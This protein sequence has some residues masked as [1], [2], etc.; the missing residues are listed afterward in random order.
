MRARKRS[1]R[2]QI[3]LAIVLALL[4]TVLLVSVLSNALINRRFEAY[5]IRQQEVRTE[6]IIA[7][8][9]DQYDAL[10]GVWDLEFIHAVGMSALYDGYIVKLYDKAGGMVWDAENHDMTLCGQIMEEIAKRMKAWNPGASGEF[11]SHEYGLS[12]N[13][14]AAGRVVILYF[15][16]YF[17][18]E[19][20]FA[21]L[22]ALNAVL[23]AMGIVS[24][25]FSLVAG[26]FL[27]RRI[28]RPISGAAGI[29]RQIAAGNYSIRFESETGT[30]ELDELIR[31]VNHLAGALEEQEGIRKQLTA[32]VAH[33]LR[34]PL[35]AAGSHLEAMLEGV[36]EPTPQRLESC[37]EEIKRLS[38]LVSDMERLA[39]VERSG[40]KLHMAEVDLMD[41]VRAVCGNFEKDIR[42]KGLRLRI[43]GESCLL[44]ADRDRLGQI[45][46][47]L[48]SNAGKFT[49]A[50]GT[51]RVGAARSGANAVLTVADDGVGIS[52]NELPFIFER[53][54]RADKSRNRKTGGAGIG[55]AI[56]KSIAEAHGG[57]VAAESRPDRGSC[58]TVTLP[59]AL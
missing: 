29:A 32:D 39:Q 3:S 23:I 27:A 30:R 42:D 58:F 54:Y 52:E 48:L 44:T 56:V 15:G 17:L 19:N 37:H 28:A 59:G 26:W 51:V 36:W 11:A 20:D 41:V 57:A 47:N 38:G 45:A 8:L 14:A 25:L 2:T 5:V 12:Q 10:T 34:T 9:A 50:G 16:P 33:E 18:S 43:E 40:F 22:S 35:A 21:F 55:L 53:F 1:L 24:L 13:G 6:D 46:V 4:L 7:S 31:A 49:P